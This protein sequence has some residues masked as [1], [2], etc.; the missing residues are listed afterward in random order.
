MM[1]PVLSATGESERLLR[2]YLIYLRERGKVMAELTIKTSPVSRT[3]GVTIFAFLLIVSSLIHIHKL[4]VDRDMYV[5][6]YSYWPTWLIMLRYS[7]SWFQRILGLAAGIG[8]L[9]LKEIGRRI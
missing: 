1:P 5:Y 7:F 9:S 6:L 3:R 4:I 8:I 2:R